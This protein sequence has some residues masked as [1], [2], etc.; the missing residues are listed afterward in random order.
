MKTATFRKGKGQSSLYQMKPKVRAF[1]EGTF[2][3]TISNSRSTLYGYGDTIEG[4]IRNAI[5]N[6]RMVN[7]LL[8]TILDDFCDRSVKSIKDKVSM[9]KRI[10]AWVKSRIYKDS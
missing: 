8:D 6:K 4:A 2:R 5:E 1:P 7:D 3:F 10:V 9:F